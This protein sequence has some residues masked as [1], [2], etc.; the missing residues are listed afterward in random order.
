[1]QLD[2]RSSHFVSTGSLA[3]QLAIACSQYVLPVKEQ[4]VMAKPISTLI[5]KILI[6]NPNFSLDDQNVYVDFVEFAKK[7]P[8]IALKFIQPFK[9]DHG[10]DGVLRAIVNTILMV[11]EPP[12]IDLL[13]IINQVQDEKIRK[14]LEEKLSK[15]PTKEKELAFR[16]LKLI[17]DQNDDHRQEEKLDLTALEKACR[18]LPVEQKDQI[19]LNVAQEV[20]W[21][22]TPDAIFDIL[23]DEAKA[24]RKEIITIVNLRQFFLEEFIAETKKKEA[25]IIKDAKE[26]KLSKI[27]LFK[28]EHVKILSTRKEPMDEKEFLRRIRTSEGRKEIINLVQKYI[29]GDV[30]A[31]SEIIVNI[32]CILNDNK[33]LPEIIDDFTNIFAANTLKIKANLLFQLLKEI[34]WHYKSAKVLLLF[35]KTVEESKKYPMIFEMINLQ[36]LF[37]AC[38]PSDK[39]LLEFENLITEK[40]TAAKVDNYTYFFELVCQYCNIKDEIEVKKN[41]LQELESEETRIQ[42]VVIIKEKL[43]ASK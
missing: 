14:K 39:F 42:A 33:N 22:G 5:I 21:H 3:P 7:A 12:P 16:I 20:Q 26:R 27:E 43:L 2:N 15:P 24:T 6:K 29:E 8:Q 23:V 40:A 35:L 13:S 11:P 41:F 36:L 31:P 37:I 4:R 28:Q 18:D 38:C 1:M 34:P 19:L 17:N 32:Q 30:Q 25:Q 9:A 10:K